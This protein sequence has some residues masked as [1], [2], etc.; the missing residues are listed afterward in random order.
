M[1]VK[2]GEYIMIDYDKTV[3]QFF[4]SVIEF[5]QMRADKSCDVDER[6]LIRRNIHRIRGIMFNPAENCDYAAQLRLGLVV[7][8]DGFIRPGSRNNGIYRAYKG[9]EG[10]IDKYYSHKRQTLGYL[11]RADSQDLLSAIKQ[12]NYAKSTSLFKDFVFSFKSKESFAAK[13]INEKQR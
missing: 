13:V 5:L 10:A 12:W 3:E 9:V 7:Q 6:N 8:P 4:N 1:C 2:S 11:A